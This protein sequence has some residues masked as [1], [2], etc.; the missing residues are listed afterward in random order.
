MYYYLVSSTAPAKGIEPSQFFAF[1][2]WNCTVFVQ[3]ISI[4]TPEYIDLYFAI[5]YV[6]TVEL[7]DKELFGHPTVV[8]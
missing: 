1:K 3:I 5:Y 4:E 7:G 2:V 8:P 6:C